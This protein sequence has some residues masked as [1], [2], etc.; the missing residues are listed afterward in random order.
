MGRSC[1]HFL[2]EVG[3]EGGHGP[4]GSNRVLSQKAWLG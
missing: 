2:P 4:A 3:D 1:F